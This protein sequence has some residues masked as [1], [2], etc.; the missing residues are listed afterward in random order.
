MAGRPADEDLLGGLATVAHLGVIANL[1]DAQLIDHFLARKGKETGEVAE[2]AFEALV[3]R[4]GA[5]VF[6]V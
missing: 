6:D 1:S 4:H 5:M 2:P 3:A